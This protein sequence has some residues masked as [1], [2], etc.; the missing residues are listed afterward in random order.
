MSDGK[1]YFITKYWETMGIVKVIG[2][3]SGIFVSVRREDITSFFKYKTEVFSSI[4]EAKE[5]VLLLKERRIKSLK[6]KLKKLME[7]DSSSIKVV[8]GF[9]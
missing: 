2:V 3:H 4:S 9:Q 6:K 1:T 5:M 8:D 7:L